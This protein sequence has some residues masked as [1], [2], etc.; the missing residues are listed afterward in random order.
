MRLPSWL[1]L[2]LRRPRG[3]TVVHA[4]GSVSPCHLTRYQ[5]M[6]DGTELWTATLPPGAQYSLEHGDRMCIELLPP[7]VAVVVATYK[8]RNENWPS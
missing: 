2:R 8:Q 1:W 7:R 5:T 4:D 6:P 3:V